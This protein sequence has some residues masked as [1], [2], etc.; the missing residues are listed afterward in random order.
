MPKRQ[1]LAVGGE[2][3]SLYFRNLRIED[4][5]QKIFTFEHASL[6]A[7]SLFVAPVERSSKV[8]EVVINHRSRG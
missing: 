5:P 8:Y 6:P 2:S 3:F 7:L 1:D 4:L